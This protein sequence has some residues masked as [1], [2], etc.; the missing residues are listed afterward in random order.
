MRVD[1]ASFLVP[2]HWEHAYI[3]A[4]GTRLHVAIAGPL[5]GEMVV[6]LHG[7]PQNWY[8]WRA[9]LP[10]LAAAGYRAI[11]MDLPGFGAS[12]KPP[13]HYDALS[14]AAD[15]SAVIRSLGASNAVIIGHGYGAQVAWS[16]PGLEPEVTRAIG[17]LSSPH[18]IPLRRPARL[19]VRT[20]AALAYAQLPWL[21]ERALRKDWTSQ[22]LRS[23]GAPGWHCEAQKFYTDAM[24]QP[25]VAH[26]VLEQARWQVRSIRRTTGIQYMA[27]VREPI[28]VP[29]LGLHGQQDRCLP[30][31][32]RDRDAEYVSGRY[33][34]HT[35]ARAGHFLPEEAPELVTQRIVAFL[36]S[37]D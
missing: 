15:V 7:F 12:D 18:P 16:M 10:A 8:A 11:A 32:A 27:A 6:L 34:F 21:P 33:A 28:R 23:W 26:S 37:L 30:L 36:D 20:R 2:G 9:Q 35:M 19:P 22:V 1:P 4:N 24:R 25:A 17:T 5:T 29:V 13:G 31:S 3:A 14:I